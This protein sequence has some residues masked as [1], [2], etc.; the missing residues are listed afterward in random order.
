M[1]PKTISKK[2]L[3]EERKKRK[4]AKR[5]TKRQAALTS[6]F[7]KAACGL[8]AVMLISLVALFCQNQ[9]T[10]AVTEEDTFPYTSK[11]V[12]AYKRTFENGR[13]ADTIKIEVHFED[14]NWY[15]W[16][17]NTFSDAEIESMIG[18]NLI[19]TMGKRMDGTEFPV[20]VRNENGYVYRTIEE[21]NTDQAESCRTTFT[22]IGLSVSL[23]YILILFSIFP[24]KHKPYKH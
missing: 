18:S 15:R 12:D 20:E 4:I 23:L 11:C 24:Y 19:L 3:L 10:P 16:N 13:H 6:F 1:D 14:G 22:A 5:K 7:I 9:A 21:Y 2:E 17:E 8:L